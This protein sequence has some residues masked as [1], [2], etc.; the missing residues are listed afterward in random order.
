MKK[1]LGFSAVCLLPTAFAFAQETKATAPPME[2]RQ[3]MEMMMKIATPGEGHKKLDVLVG[4]WRA[5]STMWTAPG[6][7]PSVTEGTS[8]HKW[9]LGGRFLEQRYEGTFMGMPFQGIGYT[10]YDNYRQKYLAV[11][12]DTFGT[13][14]MSTSGSF[15]PS[16]KVLESTGKV[17]DFTTGKV[18]TIR[19][20][21]T[22]VSRDEVVMEMFGPGP[23]GAEYRIMEVL[24]TRK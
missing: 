13:T 19:E 20:K 1:T 11:W 14:I 4:S 8:E 2:D 23:T 3:A 21:L 6:A 10:G 24:Y 7:E 9:V 16:G 22:F 5:K 17:D 18:A 12:M 15:D